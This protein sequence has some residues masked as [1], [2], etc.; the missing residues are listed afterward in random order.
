MKEKLESIRNFTQLHKKITIFVTAGVLVSAISVAAIFAVLKHNAPQSTK[1]YREYSVAK[2]DVTVGTTESGTVSLDTQNITFPIACTISSVSVKS[3]QTVKKGDA[4]LRLNLDSV[5]DNSSETR[6]KLET[7]KVSLQQALTDQKSKL[8]A[9]KITYESS[10]ALAQ[11]APVTRA[12]TEASIQNDIAVAQE[13][14]EKDRKE[15]AKYQA[16]QKT[17]ASDYAKLQKLKQWMDDAKTNQTSYSNQLSVFKT[18]NNAI[19]SAYEK[20]KDAVETARA[21][22]I[23]AKY[24][25]DS[26]GEDEDTA[27]LEYDSAKD[28]LDAYYNNVA[29]DIIQQQENLQAKLDQAE[30]EYTNYSKAYND[31]KETYSDK[32]PVAG[33]DLDA[34]VTSLQQSVKSDEYALSKA[35]K[36]AQITSN[37]AKTTEEKDLNTAAYAD[38]TYNLTVNQLALAVSEQQENCDKLQR[39]LDEINNALDGNGV[40]TSPCDGIVATVSYKAGDTVPASTAIMEISKPDS[41][42]LSVS[43]SEDDITGISIG[44]E[45]SITLSAYD[46]QSFD[47]MVES[48]TAEPARS[49]S[50]SVTYT[51]V[52]KMTGTDNDVGTVYT[53]MSGEATIIQKR[54]KNVLYVN[55]KAIRFDNGVSTVLVKNQ[56][57]STTEK[58]VK[59]GFSNGTNV[60][61]TSGLAEGDTVLAE[62]TVSAK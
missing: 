20:L 4:L 3:G 36:T 9:A 7:A 38:D 14:L 11:T 35:K 42:S 30:A 33:T 22:Y 56:D 59:T 51:V 45:A 31:F 2:G 28:A 24:G 50:S 5:N 43:I 25:S 61:V 19:I 13:N 48:I 52:V 46:N 55:N 58:N 16:L 6:Q 17:W 29:G 26:N 21:N 40:I 1:T 54:V 53:G 62:S 57:G 15:L 32:Y 18:D 37:E 41:V 47:A 12:L 39:E 27:K 44:Q 60:E 49:G 34:K 8:A 10:K 23:S